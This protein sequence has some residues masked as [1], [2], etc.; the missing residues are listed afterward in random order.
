MYF[1]Y[2][3]DEQNAQVN[4]DFYLKEYDLVESIT[5]FSHPQEAL[6]YAKHTPFDVAFLDIELP[7]MT[8]LTL[9]NKLKEY[10]PDIEII[11]VSA[12][13]DYHQAAYQTDGRAYLLKPLDPK[14]IASV[15]SFLSKLTP[16]RLQ[17]CHPLNT[18][19]PI[20]VQTFGNFDLWVQGEPVQFR[21][22]KA[23]E[24]LAVLVNERG[25]TV[26]NIEI[27]NLLWPDK[28][29]DKNTS[30]YV[31]RVTQALKTQ[32]NELGCGQ[33][34]TFARNAT[35]VNESTFVCDYYAITCGDRR[36]LASYK[37]YYMAQYPWA[38][39]TV[40]LIEQ[41]IKQFTQ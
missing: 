40:Y 36:Y 34:I 29:Y 31:R 27:F 9:A 5:Y 20:F 22:A 23:K 10:Q 14:N 19:P 7:E 18:K 41:S 8:G 6:D 28:I 37:G 4:L 13:A 16:T 17:Q 1:I 2:V 15:F 3:D 32:L 24:L 26:G 39:E 35:Y 21:V 38:D 12:F 25:S 11:F 33:M 30:T